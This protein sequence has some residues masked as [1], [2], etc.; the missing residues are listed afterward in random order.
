MLVVW[1]SCPSIAQLLKSSQSLSILKL[2]NVMLLGCYVFM[3]LHCFIVMLSH[4]FIVMTFMQLCCH[5][6]TLLQCSSSYVAALL[7]CCDSHII[8]FLFCQIFM[9]VMHSRFFSFFMLY[10]IMLCYINR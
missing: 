4:C 8:T 1:F 7:H 6:A 5:I 10:H 3:F 9:I 2:L